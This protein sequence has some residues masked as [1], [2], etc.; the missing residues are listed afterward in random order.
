M[1]AY[2]RDG[3]TI[4]SCLEPFLAENQRKQPDLY[5]TVS[6]PESIGKLDATLARSRH[7][8]E[9][10]YVGGPQNRPGIIAVWH[11]WIAANA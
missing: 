3:S 1:L 6:L 11:L 9:F 8:R 10:R 5:L 7:N 2:V 4:R